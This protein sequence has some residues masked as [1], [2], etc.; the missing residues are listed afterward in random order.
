MV[1]DKEVKTKSVRP[2]KQG[3]DLGKTKLTSFIKKA[4]IEVEKKK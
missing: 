2:R 4:K 3:K 1:G